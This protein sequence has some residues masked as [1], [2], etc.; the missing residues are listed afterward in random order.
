MAKSILPAEDDR[1]LRRACETRVSNFPLQELCDRI[2][3]LLSAQ[4]P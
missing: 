3:R 1:V 4:A 2:E